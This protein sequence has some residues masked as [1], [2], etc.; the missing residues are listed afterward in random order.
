MISLEKSE[1]V[2]FRN[3]IKKVFGIKQA[4]EKA[5]NLSFYVNKELNEEET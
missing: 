2:S 1:L 5:R 3:P 4:T